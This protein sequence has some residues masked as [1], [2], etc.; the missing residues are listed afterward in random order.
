MKQRCNRRGVPGS[1]RV[2]VLLG[3][4]NFND[5]RGANSIRPLVESLARE[6]DTPESPVHTVA[7]YQ[8]WQEHPGQPDSDTFDWAHPNPQGQEKMASRWFLAMSP[9]CESHKSDG[10]H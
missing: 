1:V 6:L 10:S 4:L 8:G 3:H 5:S 9:F 7:H 2:V